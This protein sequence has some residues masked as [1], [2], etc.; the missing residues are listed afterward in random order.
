MRTPPKR[1]HSYSEMM[2]A[3]YR[4]LAAQGV[5]MYVDIVRDWPD[6]ESKAVIAEID[7]AGRKVRNDD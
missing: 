1:P 5:R 4:H 2:K 3:N 6:A 7:A